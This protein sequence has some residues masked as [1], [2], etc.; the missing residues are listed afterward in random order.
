MKV[1]IIMISAIVISSMAGVIIIGKSTF[2]GTVVDNPYSHG[3]LWDEI[4]RQR[5]A[6]GLSVNTKNEL[7]ILGNNEVVISIVNKDG[8]PL[9]NASVSV[10]VSRPATRAYDKRY[11]LVETEN[12]LYKAMVNFPLYGYWDLKIDVAQKDGN[13]RFKNRI[14]ATIQK[15]E[16]LSSYRSY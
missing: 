1:L 2:G 11:D 6:S 10:V 8:S 12:G 13:I 5:I 15:T 14:F 7:L 16:D 4:Q 3:L 9:L